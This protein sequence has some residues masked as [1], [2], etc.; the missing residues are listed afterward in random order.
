MCDNFFCPDCLCCKAYE[1]FGIDACRG[2]GV[3]EEC[4]FF[5]CSYCFFWQSLLEECIPF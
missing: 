3:F 2:N 1:A 4:I 5:D